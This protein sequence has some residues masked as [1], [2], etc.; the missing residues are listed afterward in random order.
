MA[1]TTVLCQACKRFYCGCGE[2]LEQ[3]EVAD[4]SDTL[5]D[6]L[7]VS[8]S[9]EGPSVMGTDYPV[10]PDEPDYS[11]GVN[12]TVG[13]KLEHFRFVVVRKPLNDQCEP[14]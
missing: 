10:C 3:N 4:Q 8:T 5:K 6:A 7:P 12:W 13:K 11:K 9:I 14:I 1:L 2:R